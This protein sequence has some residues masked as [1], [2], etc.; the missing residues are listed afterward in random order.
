MTT[1]ELARTTSDAAQRLKKGWGWFI[2]LG[3]L[4]LGLGTFAFVYVGVATIASMLTIGVLMAIGGVAHIVLAFRG[5]GWKDVLLLM[6]GGVFYL[7]AG[8][9]IF[10][11]PVLASSI[12]TLMIAASL[13][14][15]GVV[16]IWF[17]IKARPEKS[18]G[19]MALAGVVTLLL[20]LIIA[21]GWPVNSLFIIGMFLAVDLLMQGWSYIALGWALRAR[22]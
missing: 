5:D 8:A 9:L 1:T 7:L 20:G 6:L 21:L 11:N 19:W 4:L 10:I 16:R 18:W 2:A 3:V 22:A 12:L 13:L 15:V 17:G 14:V